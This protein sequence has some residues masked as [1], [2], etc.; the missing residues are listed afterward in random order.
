MKIRIKDDKIN[1]EYNGSLYDFSMEEFNRKPR[2]V[3]QKIFN[4]KMDVLKCLY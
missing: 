1:V 2:A 4:I 3:I